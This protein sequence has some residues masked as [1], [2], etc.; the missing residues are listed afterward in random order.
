MLQTQPVRAPGPKATGID[1][2]V[3]M[4]QAGPVQTGEEQTQDFH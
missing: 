3:D 1:S 4:T 2:E